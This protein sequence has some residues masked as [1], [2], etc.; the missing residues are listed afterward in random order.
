MHQSRGVT[1]QPAGAFMGDPVVA[2]G[3][4]RQPHPGGLE[5]VQHGRLRLD[6]I[7]A[8]TGLAVVTAPRPAEL[9]PTNQLN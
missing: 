9:P 5:H 3:R 8:V 7:R 6:V 1:P 2:R 4:A